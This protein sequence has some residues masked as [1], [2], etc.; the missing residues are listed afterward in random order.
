MRPEAKQFPTITIPAER[1]REILRG[2]SLSEIFRNL[3]HESVQKGLDYS[4]TLCFQTWFDDEG[5]FCCENYE[6]GKI[7]GRD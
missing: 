5:N 2:S 4:P 6:P 7:R 3:R 1:F